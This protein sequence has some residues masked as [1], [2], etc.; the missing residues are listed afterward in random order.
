MHL[1]IVYTLDCRNDGT[2]VDNHP[3][4]IGKLWINTIHMWTTFLDTN[5]SMRLRL[6]VQFS[7]AAI[8]FVHDKQITGAFGISKKR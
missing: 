8:L 5:L 2:T 7:H 3:F 6:A 1:H 4:R